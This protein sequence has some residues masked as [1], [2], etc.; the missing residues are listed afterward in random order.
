MTRMMLFWRWWVDFVLFFFIL[1]SVQ[2]RRQARSNL[3]WWLRRGFTFSRDDVS[4]C[5]IKIS[6]CGFESEPLTTILYFCNFLRDDRIMRAVIWGGIRFLLLLL[7]PLL[8]CILS[9]WT[10]HSLATAQSTALWRVL[11]DSNDCAPHR[12]C[13]HSTKVT[14]KMIQT[15]RLSHILCER[16]FDYMKHSGRMFFAFCAREGRVGWW[17]RLQFTDHR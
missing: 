16:A 13:L 4:Y 2:S 6:L 1:N 11:P 8:L 10:T 17:G 3:S 12:L 5:T 14:M 15:T 9:H 7:L